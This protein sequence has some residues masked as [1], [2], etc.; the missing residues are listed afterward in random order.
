MTNQTSTQTD[1][2]QIAATN[3]ARGLG[4]APV[5]I[6]VLAAVLALLVAPV[7]ANAEGRSAVTV[8]T[9]AAGTVWAATVLGLCITGWVRKTR[10]GNKRAFVGSTIVSLIL[11]GGVFL[12]GASL[13]WR[14][15]TATVER[16]LGTPIATDE[17]LTFAFALAAAVLAAFLIGEAIAI[18]VQLPPAKAMPYDWRR[19]HAIL[20][21]VGFVSTA[22]ELVTRN[23]S[24]SF[25]ERGTDSGVGLLVLA[26]W[27]LPLAAAIAVSQRHWGSKLR[28]A[29]TALAIVMLVASGVRS[30]L[31]L[32]AIAALPRLIEAIATS[33][34]SAPRWLGLA[35][36]AYIVLT[37]AAAI[38]S[39]RGGIRAGRTPNLFDELLRQ[40]TNPNAALT[41]SGIDTLDGMLLVQSVDTRQFEPS[42]LDLLKV[43][44]TFLPRQLFPEKPPLLS[45]TIS[46][47]VLD[48]GAAGM[49]LSGPGYLLVI[50]GSAI[51]VLALFALGGFTFNLMTGVVANVGG[52]VLAYTLLRFVMGGDA[53]DFYQGL[54]LVLL[55]VASRL[56]IAV[57][58]GLHGRLM[59]RGIAGKPRGVQSRTI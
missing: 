26:S 16:L 25:A 53:F 4:R 46:Q 12:P 17:K 56:T 42:M 28:L 59:R 52:A 15:R 57:V 30:P 2:R 18:R 35:A 29:S 58:S 1:A 20:F 33:R 24:D 39:W 49:F 32:I 47:S 21:I 10:K 31:L 51:A 34:F 27:C 3:S 44:T 6:L 23:V 37:T 41:S 11:L 48:F 5:L 36:G 43:F 13:V 40:A 19:A 9:W 38:S 7:L 45:N 14:T 22:P 50:S 55:L 8:A 54:T